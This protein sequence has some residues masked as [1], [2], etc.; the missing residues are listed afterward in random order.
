[1]STTLIT[2]ERELSPPNRAQAAEG[3]TVAITKSD[4]TVFDPPLSWI[5]VGGSGDL[6]LELANDIGVART[7]K[8]IPIGLWPFKIRKVMSTNTAATDMVGGR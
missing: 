6:A 5:Y 4:S 1:M 2:S 8:S 3:P 7:Y